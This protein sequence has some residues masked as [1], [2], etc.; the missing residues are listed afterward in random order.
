MNANNYVPS[1]PAAYARTS[2]AT[3]ISLNYADALFRSPAERFL[4]FP[5]LFAVPGATDELPYSHQ[6]SSE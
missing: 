4:H 3:A 6:L 5:D 2:I 1:V